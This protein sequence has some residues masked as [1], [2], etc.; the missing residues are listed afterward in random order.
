MNDAKQ[1]GRAEAE[2]PPH[3]EALDYRQPDS[4]T[5]TPPPLP[6]W[7]GF[8]AA[9]TAMGLGSIAPVVIPGVETLNA[10]LIFLGLAFVVALCELAR[11][12]SAQFLFGYIAGA[13]LVLVFIAVLLGVLLGIIRF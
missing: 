9:W 4:P 1:N 11:S 6:A 3:A 13:L 10:I 5:E 8:A 7:L 12:R 2:G